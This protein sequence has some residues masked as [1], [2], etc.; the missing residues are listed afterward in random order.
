[1]FV[2]IRNLLASAI[3][4]AFIGLY[5]CAAEGKKTEPQG[6]LATHIFDDGRKQ[7]VYTAELP[8]AGNRGPGGKSGGRP[9]NVA[10]QLNGSS[11]GGLSGG[12]IAGTGNR[13]PGGHPR[14]PMQSRD[15]MLVT[16]VGKELEKSGYCR[17]GYKE[18]DR[19]A[20]PRQTYLKGE[21]LDAAN[22]HDRKQ[23]PNT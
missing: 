2:C 1:M 11:N 9:G 22:A 14:G 16:A 15:D 8:D 19:M 18:L 5:G 4:V 17:E 20:E 12:V 6:Y 23:F 7:F 10:G 13:R 21:C 3:F